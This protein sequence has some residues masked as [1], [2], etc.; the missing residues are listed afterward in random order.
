MCN[1]HCINHEIQVGGLEGVNFASLD[2]HN[3]HLD[4][5]ESL[6]SDR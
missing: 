5:V 3:L 2:G 1:V 6:K 4:I